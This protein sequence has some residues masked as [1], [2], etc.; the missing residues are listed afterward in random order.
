MAAKSGKIWLKRLKI[1]LVLI[2]VFCFLLSEFIANDKPILCSKNGNISSPCFADFKKLFSTE[3]HIN[4]DVNWE[5][6]SDWAIWPPI[7]YSPY[8]IDILNQQLKPPFSR[9]NGEQMHLLGTDE[10][11]RDILSRIIYGGRISLFV[12]IGASLLA[13]FIGIFLGGLAGL[14]GDGQ[15]RVN[16]LGIVLILVWIVFMFVFL[17]NFHLDPSPWYL[18][19]CFISTIGL[20]IFIRLLNKHLSAK[21]PLPVDSIIM[22][23]V[24]I[25]KSIPVLLVLMSIAV[26]FRSSLIVLI[27]IIG[28]FSWPIFALL[29]RN[30][31]LSLKELNFSQSARILGFSNFRL[32][33]KELLPLAF[34]ILLVN[35]SLA[36][37]VAILFEGN[38]SFL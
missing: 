27:L 24:D 18:F 13:L 21:I 7:Q 32:L 28:L 11:G 5:K 35:F 8:K 34:P 15:L 3:S 12:G 22:R 31:L 6:E 19:F 26:L 37:P 10:L 20:L 14:Y 38:I 1:S 9:F 30:Q 16:L 23:L 33:T 2:S 25:T 36:I 17:W 4:S 29:F